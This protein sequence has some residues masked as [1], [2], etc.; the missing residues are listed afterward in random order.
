MHANDSLII[1]IDGGQQR[2]L[3]ASCACVLMNSLYFPRLDSC[4][5]TRTSV[6]DRFTNMIER[7][8]T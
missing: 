8:T 6:I 2:K 5:L 1:G 7:Y 4:C 3:L